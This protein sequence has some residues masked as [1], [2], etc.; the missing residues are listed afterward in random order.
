MKY[1]QLVHYD[2]QIVIGLLD[3]ADS[4]NNLTTFDTTI[5]LVLLLLGRELSSPYS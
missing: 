1:L 4:G 2:G 3:L 5:S